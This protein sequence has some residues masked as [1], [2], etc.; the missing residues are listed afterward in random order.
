MVKKKYIN[1]FVILLTF[2]GF[3]YIMSMVP[4]GSDDWAWGGLVGAQRLKSHFEN[5]NGRYLG[6]LLIILLTKS[7][8]VKTIG[9]AVVS[10]SV[11]YLIYKYIGEKS[12]YYFLFAL[13]LIFIMPANIYRQTMGWASGLAN[14]I[15]PVALTLLYLNLVKNIFDDEKPQYSKALILPSFVIGVSGNL[16]MEHITFMNIAVSLGVLIYVYI[17]FKSFYVVHFAN[18]IGNALGFAI[19]FSNSAYG[20]IASGGDSYRS[21]VKSSNTFE[22]LLNGVDRVFSRSVES[23]VLI[24]IVIFILI[25]TLIINVIN[26]ECVTQKN[27]I[28]LLIMMFYDC[29]YCVFTAIKEYSIVSREI[30]TTPAMCI[31][32]AVLGLLFVATLILIP[33]LTVKNKDK[34]FKMIIP[35]LAQF[36][37]II[38]LFAVSPVTG[39]CFYPVYIMFMIYC[40]EIL[41]YIINHFKVQIKVKNILCAMLLVGVII[42]GSFYIVKYNQ[43]SDFETQRITYLQ[44]QINDGKSTVYL[45]EYP[46]NLKAYT[47]GTSP[48]K[49]KWYTIWENRYK[50]FWGIDKNINIEQISYEKYCAVI[51]EK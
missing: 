29:F 38:P 24:N 48:Q 43:I 1:L 25:L 20:I 2:C 47:E 41:R 42:S 26:K 3:L 27:K 34:A 11:V 14:Y 50:D 46:N 23:N 15:P 40:C 49:Y 31:V 33:F 12:I 17:K 21:V 10:F 6:N 44:E 36:V 45:P 13:F 16:F 4:F 32:R 9:M 28:I 51:G 19:M 30:F 5:Y 7:N 22:W 35:I 18:F 39:R 37:L 8:A